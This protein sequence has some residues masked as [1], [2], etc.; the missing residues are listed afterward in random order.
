MSFKINFDILNQEI[1]LTNV[2]NSDRKE[3]WF[4]NSRP[5]IPIETKPEDLTDNQKISLV[6]LAIYEGWLDAELLC[7]LPKE[8]FKIN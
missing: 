2:L 3:W 4:T 8:S 6:R 1:D 5:Q 7:N